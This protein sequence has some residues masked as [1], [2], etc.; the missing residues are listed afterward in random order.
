MAK[1]KTTT[2]SKAPSANIFTV[3]ELTNAGRV[4]TY[5]KREATESELQE[6]FSNAGFPNSEDLTIDII[7][8]ICNNIPVLKS[9]I[10]AKLTK[11]K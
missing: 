4:T 8:T 9:F 3:Q 11:I 7:S 5:T 6:I 10:K 2:E 1:K